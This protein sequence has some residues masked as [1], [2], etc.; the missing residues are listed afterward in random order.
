VQRGSGH[1]IDVGRVPKLEQAVA[2]IDANIIE[3]TALRQL[4]FQLWGT[5]IVPFLDDL[6]GH[7]AGHKG[8]IQQG[9]KQYRIDPA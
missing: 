2:F 7:R 4:Q 1:I 5:A 3:F 8:Q 6:E 9:N